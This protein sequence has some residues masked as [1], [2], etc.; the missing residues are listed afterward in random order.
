MLGEH[1]FAKP[2]KRPSYTG[3]ELLIGPTG[4][5]WPHPYQNGVVAGRD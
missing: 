5:S 1:L 2:G 4:H 3:T